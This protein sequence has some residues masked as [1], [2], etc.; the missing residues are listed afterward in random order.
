[1]ENIISKVSTHRILFPFKA[2][3][4]AHSSCGTFFHK[5]TNT[6]ISKFRSKFIDEF[7]QNNSLIY[8]LFVIVVV[9]VWKYFCSIYKLNSRTE[10]CFIFK[11]SLENILT[12]SFTSHFIRCTASHR[13]RMHFKKQSVHQIFSLKMFISFPYFI[14]FG[15]EAF[16][17]CCGYINKLLTAPSTAITTAAIFA[18]FFSFCT[19]LIFY[20]IL[21][22]LSNTF[23]S[24]LHHISF[25]HCKN[26]FFDSM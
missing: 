2:E 12:L 13:K 19:S 7:I 26:S 10:T 24:P 21:F 4:L 9:V 6:D 18:T 15:M 3:V 20:L 23:P 14:R 16:Q 8:F 25:L 22:S 11:Y 1:M 17:W 5:H